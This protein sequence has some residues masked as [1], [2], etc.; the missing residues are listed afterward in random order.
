MSLRLGYSYWGFLG[1]YKEDDRGNALSTPDGNATYSWSIIHESQRRGWR[2]YSMQR[3]RDMIPV[4]RH[5]K[6]NFSSFSGEKR[7]SSYVKMQK[8]D[9]VDLP[10]LD[11]LLLEWRFP[12][13]GRNTPEVRN[14]PGY[15]PD[16]ER[17]HDLLRHYLGT[18][19]R[20]ILWD[21]DHKLTL[22]D[23]EC[24]AE[25]G[26]VD[27]IFETS[28]CPRVQM[29]KR[30]RVEP[31][32]VYEELSQFPTLPAQESRKLA[33]IGSR[34]ERDDVID[35]YIRPV[36]ERFPGQVEF[37]GNWLNE[38]NHSEVLRMWPHIQ[39]CRRITTRDFRSV[40]GN[41]VAC[42]LLAKRSY[43]ETGFI[44][45][46]V[47]EALMFGCIPIG[48]TEMKGIEQYVLRAVSSADEL[49]DMLRCMSSYDPAE[50]H[51]LRMESINKIAFMDVRNFVDS[52]E[53]VYN[54]R[55]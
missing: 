42:P 9:G 8:T 39:Y 17:Q 22:S 31:P 50:R 47:W 55:R 11:V 25:Y 49:G 41:A 1:D 52:I 44:T 15:Q 12:I 43:F 40:Y 5:G 21:L 54:R 3:D 33:Y 20:V 46:R 16:L 27:A 37:W 4:I 38:S 26:G 24:L 7:Y 32:V 29:W 10:P 2:T 19:T 13:P 35:Q 53:E 18:K 51:T 36:S 28:V 34:Y 30:T 48:L 6:N 14:D 45:P 23:E